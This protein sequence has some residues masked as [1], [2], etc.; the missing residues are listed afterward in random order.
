MAF[1]TKAIQAINSAW[2]KF[3]HTYDVTEKTARLLWQNKKRIVASV[4]SWLGYEK[5]SKSDLIFNSQ[6]GDALVRYEEG[7]G[8]LFNENVMT[9][10]KNN[11]VYTF[12]DSKDE[13]GIKW[14]SN[15]PNFGD[16]LLEEIEIRDNLGR[17]SRINSRNID[18]GKGIESDVA[19]MTYDF[20]N[21]L[22]NETRA[23]IRQ[24]LRENYAERC[25]EMENNLSGLI[26]KKR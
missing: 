25:R 9:I 26:P 3:N 16:D 21:E 7:R 19:A 6:I 2:T 8:I 18:S 23:K 12:I 20:G 15:E 10:R 4:A 1:F 13:H 5:L 14:K 22:Y 11:Y 24:V 17:V